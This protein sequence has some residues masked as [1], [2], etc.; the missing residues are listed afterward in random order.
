MKYKSSSG[1]W[2][3]YRYA[4]TDGTPY[5]SGD[6]YVSWTYLAGYVQMCVKV[7]AYDSAGHYLGS[8]YRYVTLQSGG[9]GGGGG[10]PVPK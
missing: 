4:G 7:Q 2:T 9:E 10:D 8:D 6:Y 5:Y 1:Y 3:S